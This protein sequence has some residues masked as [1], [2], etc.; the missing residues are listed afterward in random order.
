[1]EDAVQEGEAVGPPAES[2]AGAPGHLIWR[3]LR[4]FTPELQVNFLTTFIEHGSPRDEGIW[5]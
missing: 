1:M 2:R 4:K 5:I 3:E